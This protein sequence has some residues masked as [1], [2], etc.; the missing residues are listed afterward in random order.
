[1]KSLESF[2]VSD[3]DHDH[4]FDEAFELGLTLDCLD[5]TTDGYPVDEQRYPRLG[6]AV[7]KGKGKAEEDAAGREEEDIVAAGGS[8][9]SSTIHIDDNDSVD[10]AVAMEHVGLSTSEG[11]EDSGV[12]SRRLVFPELEALNLGDRPRSA[13][14]VGLSPGRTNPSAKR[15]KVS[16]ADGRSPL[17]RAALEDDRLRRLEQKLEEGE[18]ERKEMLQQMQDR[19]AEMKRIQE[20][21]DAETKEALE[22]QR[23]NH[24]ELIQMFAMAMGRQKEA[25]LAP[26]VPASSIVQ[27]SVEAVVLPVVASPVFV[28]PRP[29]IVGASSTGSQSQIRSP[30]AHPSLQ[31]LLPSP[32]P[33]PP[34]RTQSQGDVPDTSSGLSPS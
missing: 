28:V 32:P 33:S 29:I 2:V 25:E 26:L 14:T 27:P 22:T 11:F 7:S 31:E 23:R 21:R 13:P 18:R 17:G 20:Q 12:A 19:E 9:S 16:S 6:K 24:Q 8:I 4:D 1:M 34:P 15:R 5:F 10:E 30:A 3:H